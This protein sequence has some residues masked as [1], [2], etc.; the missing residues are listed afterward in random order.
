[1]GLSKWVAGWGAAVD[2]TG[3]NYAEYFRDETFRY[4]VFST[5][6][7]TALRLHFSNKFND[8]KTTITA[9]NVAL[10]VKEDIIDKTT[11]APVTFNGGQTSITMNA[12]EESVVSDPVVFKISAGQEFAVNMYFKDMT[13]SRT[14]HSNTG[15]HIRKYFARGNHT[16]SIQL[17]LEVYGENEP[18]LFINTIDFL[19]STDSEAIIAF[20][21]SIT[22]QP[23]PDFLAH[24]IFENGIVNRAVVRKAIGGN[25]I[26]R[27]YPYRIKKLWGPAGIKRFEADISQA[28][29]TKVFLLQ[30]INDILHPAINSKYCDISQFPTFD[31]L[32]LG[33]NYYIDTAKAHNLKIYFATLLPCPRLLK[34]VPQKEEMRV[35]VNEWIRNNKRIDGI[36]DFEIAV[37]APENHKL[38]ITEYDSGDHL[39]PSVAGASHMADS[40]PLDFITE[41]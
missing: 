6:N 7:A 19:T 10:C 27:D 35:K 20:G 17:P 24:R 16:E 4:I 15:F 14:G 18:Y 32:V 33:Y 23:W 9:V 38:M 1:M 28:G 25:R 2:I 5:L 34:D 8:E 36:I 11:I 31:E 13:L 22:A 40:V 37:W 12:Y 21:D 30:G 26:L 3:Q 39:H 29:V 41:E